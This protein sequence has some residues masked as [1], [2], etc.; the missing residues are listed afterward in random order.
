MTQIPTTVTRIVE[1]IGEVEDGSPITK[2]E[3]EALASL[4]PAVKRMWEAEI[5]G[6]KPAVTEAE[7]ARMRETMRRRRGRR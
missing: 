5:A 3:M 2:T 1:A 7:K 4:L 6:P